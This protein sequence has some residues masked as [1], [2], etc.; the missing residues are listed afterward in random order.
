MAAAGSGRFAML[1]ATLNNIWFITIMV[2]G[3]KDFD[4]CLKSEMK[5]SISE[6]DVLS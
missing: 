2:S 1:S 5:K 6:I 3:F 4:R